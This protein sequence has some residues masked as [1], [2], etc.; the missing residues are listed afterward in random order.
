VLIG[1]VG[2]SMVGPGGMSMPPMGGM[3]A[4]GAASAALKGEVGL[5]NYGKAIKIEGDEAF[6]KQVQADLDSIAKTPSGKKLLDDLDKS[7]KTV[8]I[9]KTDKGNSCARTAD[10]LVRPDGTNG[11]GCDSTV[12]YNPDNKSLGPADWQTRPPAV[13]LAHELI[14][15]QHNSEGSNDPSL[16]DN[17]SKPDPKNPAATAQIKR[18]EVRT[19]GIPP[20]DKGPYT[21]NKIRAEWDPPQPQRPW[22]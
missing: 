14:H 20:H 5:A 9:K 16:V 18:E 21:E 17:D 11:P 12:N 3:A 6:Q 2:F 8:T 7:G 1:D 13:G 15:A 19:A 10:G 4:T 22:Y